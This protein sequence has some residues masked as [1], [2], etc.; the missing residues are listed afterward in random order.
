[1]SFHTFCQQFNHFT[2]LMMQP[3]FDSLVN[4]NRILHFL[5]QSY[6]WKHFKNICSKS[7]A[8]ELY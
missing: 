4:F 6:Y 7:H 3:N 8:Q 5:C 2:L 1:M